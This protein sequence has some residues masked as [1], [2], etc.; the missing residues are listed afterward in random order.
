METGRM[1]I[2]VMWSN[3]VR[4]LVWN[5]STL[6]FSINVHGVFVCELL[7][8]SRLHLYLVRRSRTHDSWFAI[9]NTLLKWPVARPIYSLNHHR[10]TTTDT[11]T[12]I[13]TNIIAIII[14]TADVDITSGS[15]IILLSSDYLINIIILWL[16]LPYYYE[17][18]GGKGRGRRRSVII[19]II[20]LLSFFVGAICSLKCLRDRRSLII[21]GPSHPFR[22]L[23]PPSQ[24][25]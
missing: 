5:G 25:A 12:T 3:L 2:F 15:W 21:H 8:F 17:S 1:S 6:I 7:E 4:K 18:D 16:I 22:L 14:I 11:I 23:V 9:I 24:G 19:I 10:I 13:T 20:N